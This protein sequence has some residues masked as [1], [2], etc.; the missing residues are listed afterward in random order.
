MAVKL[1]KQDKELIEGKEPLPSEKALEV[2]NL[3]ISF[4]TD[5]GK[6]QAVRGV[7]FDL[8]K[9]ETLCI[10][11]E[12]GSGKSTLLHC[13]AGILVPD[14]GSVT[15]RGREVARLDERDFRR[16]IVPGRDPG[17]GQHLDAVDLEG[18]RAPRAGNELDEAAREA[19]HR[20]PAYAVE[21]VE[22][23][24]LQRALRPGAG[25]A[26]PEEGVVPE[27]HGLLAAAEV[28]RALPARLS[29]PPGGVQGRRA[30][31]RQQGAGQAGHGLRSGS[32]L[33][34]CP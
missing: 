22:G 32:G 9:G 21:V 25:F 2:K 13:L 20:R 33:R 6:V 23:A 11:G 16:G 30:F 31:A 19:L 14:D 27:R 29:A 24:L 26:A 1:S 5:N 10:V 15:L 28:E 12:S 8:Y 7:S 34:P 17:G 4:R 3:V 18:G